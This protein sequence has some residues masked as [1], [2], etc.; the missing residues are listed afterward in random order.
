MLTAPA[1]AV[2]HVIRVLPRAVAQSRESFCQSHEQQI[3]IMCV[4]EM[5]RWRACA[6]HTCQGRHITVSVDRFDGLQDSVG[7]QA[8]PLR[9]GNSLFVPL[10][11]GQLLQSCRQSGR[12]GLQGTHS[13][14]A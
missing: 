10:A 6:V 14:V 9:G 5:G 7:C 12:L 1:L 3:I 2:E 4:A 8:P 13:S 11:F